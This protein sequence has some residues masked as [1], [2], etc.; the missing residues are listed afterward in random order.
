LLA[1]IQ[2]VTCRTKFAK[3]CQGTLTHFCVYR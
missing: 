1:E 2:E 3:Y